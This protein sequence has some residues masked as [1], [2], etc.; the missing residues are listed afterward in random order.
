MVGHLPTPIC[1]SH[2]RY[3]I[4]GLQ[5]RKYLRRRGIG[6]PSRAHPTPAFQHLRRQPYLAPQATRPSLQKPSLRLIYK[7]I[8]TQMN[9][10]PLSLS[11]GVSQ[12]QKQAHLHVH[13]STPTTP[14][15]ALPSVRTRYTP[16]HAHILHLA[17]FSR[18][19]PRPPGPVG[20]EACLEFPG[21]RPHRRRRHLLRR[22]YQ[23]LRGEQAGGD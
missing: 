15:S 19:S 8:I 21:A 13:A 1:C 12:V 9:D 11:Q 20:K 7:P 22:P 17:I 23:A 14:P 10:M 2:Q 3:Y 18:H 5:Q 6:S 4:S 16:L